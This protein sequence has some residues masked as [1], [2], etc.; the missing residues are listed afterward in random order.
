MT[1]KTKLQSFSDELRAAI[2]AADKTRYQL[3]KETGIAQATLSRF[4]HG[5]GGLSTSGLDK[6]A[7][8]L[9][10]HLTTEQP[11]RKTKG[12]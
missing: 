12:N 5:L 1:K 3:S 10:L 11:T 6:I 8:A 9:G 4:M 7:A 2:D